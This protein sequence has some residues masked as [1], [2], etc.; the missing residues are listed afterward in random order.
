MHGQTKFKATKFVD[1]F[2]SLNGL[3]WFPRSSF[4][5]LNVYY[6]DACLFL[7]SSLPKSL[8]SL[9]SVVVKGES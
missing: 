9:L 4:I 1:L 5:E 3:D 8:S 2:D 6:N 7:D